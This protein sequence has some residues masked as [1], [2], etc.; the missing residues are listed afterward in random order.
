[1]RP[2]S[3]PS[4]S[5]EQ[6]CKHLHS[7]LGDEYS[8]IINSFKINQV[9]GEDFVLFKQKDYETLSVPWK[10][11][12]KLKEIQGFSDRENR[13]STPNPNPNPSPNPSPNPVPGN[14]LNASTT[15][16]TTTER[17]LLET[18]RDI[19]QMNNKIDYL[20]NSLSQ[21]V[22]KM[23]VTNKKPPTNNFSNL[24]PTTQDKIM[25]PSPQSKIIQIIDPTCVGA[26][27][28]PKI[29]DEVPS[30]YNATS[31]PNLPKGRG[32]PVSL[33]SACDG[34]SDDVVFSQVYDES[35]NCISIIPNVPNPYDISSY[36][37]Y[38]ITIFDESGERE[39]LKSLVNVNPPESIILPK[40]FIIKT[41][42]GETIDGTIELVFGGRKMF[43]GCF[44]QG[45]AD[46]PQIL[47]D[48]TYE[49]IIKPNKSNLLPL[50]FKM[51]IHDSERT[52]SSN[53]NVN[54]PKNPGEMDFILVWGEK[55]MDL[56][57]HMWC[58]HP[59]G[60]IDH[61]FFSEKKIDKISLD[62]DER[63]GFGPETIS[64]K[65]ISG[66]KYVY[67]VHN[68]LNDAEMAQSGAKLRITHETSTLFER[69]IPN[70]QQTGARFWVVCTI[71]GTSGD[72]DFKDHFEFHNNHTDIPLKY[73]E[74]KN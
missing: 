19:E 53:Q 15:T 48:G 64:F 70:T 8:N 6:L 11:Q 58:I 59:N 54:R 16:T 21:L 23:R 47:L 33:P 9:T 3:I 34:P 56:D 63:N 68:Y 27:P 65:R 5:C 43:S 45:A 37:E 42:L 22:E 46:L 55:P 51:V 4:L 24:S 25:N 67:A 32:K 2:G 1:M 61:V 13:G 50:K 14:T 38:A 35:K 18:Q 62:V 49:V 71:D 72:I 60:T 57:S 44:T 66:C 10:F 31:L 69:C 7:S 30:L 29:T 74:I 41:P 40:K 12:K 39:V 36:G 52:T 20:S 28:I 73:K 26:D 17:E